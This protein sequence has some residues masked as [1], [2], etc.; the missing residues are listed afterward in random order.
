MENVKALTQKK[1]A[2]VFEAWRKWLV[3]HG[4]TNYYAVLNA[5]HYGVPQNR[6]RVFMVSYLGQHEPFSFPKPMPLTRRLKDILEPHV[7]EKYYLHR[8]QVEHVVE[9][10]RRKQAEGCGFKTNFQTPN[11]ISGAIK[12]KEGSREYDTYIIEPVGT[13]DDGTAFALT[14]RCGCVG[15]SNLTGGSHYP[16][17]GVIEIGAFNPMPDGTARTLKTEYARN[18]VQ[19]FARQ[20]GFGA[21]GV[22]EIG[23]ALLGYTRDSKGNIV[24]YHEISEA[25]TLHTST[26]SGNNTDQFVKEEGLIHL[27]NIYDSETDPMNGRVYSPEGIAPTLR[28]PTG[29]N[30]SP[31]IMAVADI[32]HSRLR[33]MFE[34][35]KI[36]PDKILFLDAYNQ[37]VAEDIAGTLTT[38]VDRSNHTWVSIPAGR[39]DA[40]YYI[41][42]V[43]IRKLT[44]RECFRLMGVPEHHIDSLVNSGISNSQ[45]YKLAGNSIV[46]DNLLHIFRKIFI[47]TS[48]EAGA[49]LAHSQEQAEQLSLF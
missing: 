40:P 24:N 23:K 31:F 35:G 21:T 49:P 26:G 18:G 13:C 6:E 27:G 15:G 17:T 48:R 3:A 47:D 43:R 2:A 45:L 42:F 20:D 30:S 34:D 8:K 4:Y 25:N 33:K 29:G 16:I 14:T 28:T 41:K 37:S 22:I 38:R 1:F 39:L 7:D 11:G 5:K 36:D 9:H 10:C 44:P 32:S 46:V 19:N 12:T